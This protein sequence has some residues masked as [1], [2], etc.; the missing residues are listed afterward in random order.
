[1]KMHKADGLAVLM[2][3][4]NN[5][6]GS[7]LGLIRLRLTEN[8]K[9]SFQRPVSLWL[10]IVSFQT[11]LTNPL[12]ISTEAWP[13]RNEGH[14]YGSSLWTSKTLHS[15]PEITSLRLHL[16]YVSSEHAHSSSPCPADDLLISGAKFSF[17]LM[18]SLH[19]KVNM[20]CTFAQY[21]CFI[22][23]YE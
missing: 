13:D 10:P 14:Q 23:P 22:F 11:P 5:D 20:G 16:L 18:L 21:A 9:L 6:M 12:A 15:S 1:M 7:L 4:K 2:G 3:S 19:L 8:L 17:I